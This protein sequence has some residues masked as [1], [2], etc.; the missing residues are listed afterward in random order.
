M[1]TI[2]YR[3]GVIA[4][5]SRIIQD[6]VIVTDDYNKIIKQGDLV[7]ALAGTVAD[8]QVF[9]DS[10]DSPTKAKKLD[11]NALVWDGKGVLD[12]YSNDK[13]IVCQPLCAEYWAIGSGAS[14]AITAMDMGA[15]AAEAVKMAKRRDTNTGGNVDVFKLR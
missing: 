15:T 12:C 11:V 14:Y 1:T 10:W 3:D 13:G 9:M 2:A 8:F 5:D 7:F 4:A 6:S